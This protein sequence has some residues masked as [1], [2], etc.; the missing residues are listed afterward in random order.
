ML[1]KL[2]YGSIIPR[3]SE[4]KREE[5]HTYEIMYEIALTK[6]RVSQDSYKEGYDD[7]SR[8]REI[9]SKCSFW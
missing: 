5:G 3:V 8:H 7:F 9:T 4:P 6:T 2:A 1:S